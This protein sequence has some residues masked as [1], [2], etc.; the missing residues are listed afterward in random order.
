MKLSKLAGGSI[1]K[2]RSGPCHGLQGVLLNPSKQ[3]L[4]SRDVMDQANDLTGSP[5]L[6]DEKSQ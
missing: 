2:Q 3:D 1:D 4:A 5:H 6:C